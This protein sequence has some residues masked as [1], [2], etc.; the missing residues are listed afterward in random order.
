[1]PERKCA[2]NFANMGN[3]QVLDSITSRDEIDA[4]PFW[5]LEFR[6]QGVR[7]RVGCRGEGVGDGSGT[8]GCGLQGPGT[9]GKNLGF[10][11]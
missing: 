9:E 3:S 1:M 8:L 5:D 4:S 2:L 7:C 6:V 10:R 11:A